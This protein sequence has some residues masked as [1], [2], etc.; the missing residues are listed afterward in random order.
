MT[1]LRLEDV[2]RVFPGPPAVFACAGGNRPRRTNRAG[3]RP[4]SGA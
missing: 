1:L 3:C 4:V 2:T